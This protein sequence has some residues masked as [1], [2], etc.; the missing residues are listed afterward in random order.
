MRRYIYII[1][2][3]AATVLAASCSEEEMDF[4]GMSVAQKNLVG[5]AV[6]F[7]VSVADNF[8]TRATSYTSDDT[9]V[10]NQNDRMCVYRNYMGDDGEWEAQEVYRT[11]YLHHRYVAGSIN[12]G[13]DWLPE[14]GRQ[15][16]DDIDGDGKYEKFVQA[17]KDS[18]TWENGKTLRFR[19]WSRSNYHNTLRGGSKSYYYPDFC[20]AEWVN[21]SGPTV[22]IPLVL[23]HQGCRIVFK[24]LQGGNQIQRV[25]LCADIN[26]DGTPRPDAWRDYKY[27]DNADS[28]LNDNSSSEAGKTDEQARAECESVS[29]VYKKMC[30]PAGVNINDRTLRAI[31][32]AGWNG[33]S[34]NDVR[35]LEEQDDAIFVNYRT[36]TPEY[37]ATDVRRPFF[38]GINGGLYM[39][40]IPYDM[41]NAS[42]HGHLLVLPPCT[43]FRVYMYDVNNGDENNTTGY[44]GK[45]HIFSLGDIMEI[46]SK[47]KVLID[48]NGNPVRAFPDGLKL[49]PGASY[50][51]KVGYRYKSL[52]VVV[53]KNLSWIPSDEESSNGSDEAVERP[54]ST[55]KDYQWWKTAIKSAITDATENA[56]D[57]KP[58]FHINNEKEFLEFINLV[59][60]TAA[61][62]T[63]ELY[64]LV[65]TYKE[66]IVGGQVVRVPDTYGWSRTNSQ[67]NPVWVEEEEAEKEGFIFYDHYYPANADMAAHSER[68]YLRGPFPFYDENLRL[69][70]SVVLDKDLDLKDWMIESVGNAVANP[71]MGNFDGGGHTIK[72]VYV[73]EECLFGYMNGAAPNG[74]S[75]TNLRIEST[76]NTALLREGVNPIYLVGISLLAPSTGNSMAGSLSMGA[77]VKGTSY[78]VGCLHV[79]N[80]GGP[81][82]GTASDVCMY[83]CMQA[84]GGITGGA[85]IGTDVKGTLRPQIKLSDQKKSEKTAA[86]KPSFLNFMCNYYDK[87]LSPSANAIGS[88]ADDYSLLE[89][90]RGSSTDILCAKNDYLAHNVPMYSL[91][92][93]GNYEN[94]YGLAPWHAMNYAIWWYNANRGARHPCAMRYVADPLSYKHRYPTL[95]QGTLTAAEVDDWNPLEQP[96]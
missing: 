68:D 44:E 5:R 56:A 58:V 77:G 23:N 28:T 6:N 64:R 20:I 59:N 66:T 26:P 32:T 4:Y 92:H 19:A 73:R 16:Y 61:T 37:I 11:Y 93:L 48:E 86:L 54:E 69:N 47:G 35:T 9:G 3:V 80:A 63:T 41:S 12:L 39:I 1:I 40:S 78:V 43:R 55:A 2:C 7:N 72:N 81:L 50:T 76:H 62:Q 67:Y 96:N 71:F 14:E 34:D 79:G 27:M 18:L 82:V 49:T 29:A 94:Y 30:M 70:F 10:F 60:G 88:T 25:E 24:V 22:G 95:T 33:L 13:M 90:V 15:G 85:L 87:T 46:D 83:G 36:R 74:A 65:K 31:T 57:Y 38:S 45:Y 42:T 51:F 89:Y 21:A 53:D 91:L 52:Y 75:V 84:A 17:D 8:V